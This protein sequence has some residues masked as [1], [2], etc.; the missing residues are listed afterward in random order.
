MRAWSTP[1]CWSLNN[2]CPELLFSVHKDDDDGGLQRPTRRGMAGI[3]SALFWA[4][5]LARAVTAAEA[6]LQALGAAALLRRHLH[7][8]HRSQPN[9][10]KKQPRP[11]DNTPA[12]PPSRAAPQASWRPGCC[13]WRS[14][15][16][17]V[18]PPARGG[19]CGL[20]GSVACLCTARHAPGTRVHL[21]SCVACGGR[22]SRVGG[23]W[24]GCRR[25]RR[26]PPL[27]PCTLRGSALPQLA[28][29]CWSGR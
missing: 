21:C 13:C 18:R 8:S 22:G 5:R 29:R 19:R 24:V 17:T 14:T 20:A 26:P 15:T 6:D 11:R 27:R 9:A 10:A 25:R 4:A 1:G 16:A 23:A 2:T 12:R 3:A 28:R 7:A